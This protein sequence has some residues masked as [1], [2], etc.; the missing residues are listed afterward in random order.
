MITEAQKTLF[1]SFSGVG[2]ARGFCP[3]IKG[4][5]LL[6][7]VFVATHKLLI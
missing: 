2:I 1:F 7:E 5:I 6:A 3:H 4:M